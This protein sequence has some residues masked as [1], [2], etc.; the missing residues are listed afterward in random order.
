MITEHSSKVKEYSN[1]NYNKKLF[2]FAYKN[3]QKVI[4]VSNSLKNELKNLG[5][6]F[7]D[8]IIGNIVDT[9][10]YY[11]KDKNQLATGLNGL[12]IGL[13]NDNEVKGLQYFLP[14]LQ[15]V[16]KNY[17][18]NIKFTLIGD[19]PKRKKYEAMVN[20]LNIN[21]ICKFIGEVPK[22][23]IPEYIMNHDFL[24]LPSVKETFGSVLIEA[25]AAGKPVLATKCGGPDEF[26][27]KDVGILV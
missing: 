7:N 21:N 13:M 17:N 18:D 8:E 5:Y 1:K 27:I 2:Y 23:E 11:I 6:T 4:T 14:A 9:N 12:F 26:V 25:M 24:V 10:E 20:E 22:K 19:G 16:F 15:S 3:A